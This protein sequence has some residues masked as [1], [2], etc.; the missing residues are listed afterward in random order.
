[1]PRPKPQA[2]LLVDGYN[3]I[4][5]WSNLQC[6]RDRYGLEAARRELI[7]ALVGY[8]AFHGFDTRIVFDAQYQDTPG[9]REV[10]TPTLSICYT[11]YRQTA[12]SYIERT[13]S[14]FRSDLRKFE[15]RLIVATS[16]RAQQLT[17]VGYGAEWMSTQQLLVEVELSHQRVRR[18]QRQTHKKRSPNRF[19]SNSLDP[20]AQQR[21]AQLRMG[22]PLDEL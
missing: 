22:W 13:C 2:L 20:A 8:S 14:L 10:V 19:L 18:K 9:S 4:G 21:L 17:V 7:E 12:D 3:V 1:M 5:A 16:D 15:Q 6:A 11:D